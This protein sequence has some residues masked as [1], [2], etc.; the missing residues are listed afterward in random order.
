MNA[1]A[2]TQKLAAGASIAR[3]FEACGADAARCGSASQELCG[4]AARHAPAFG[5][6][7]GLGKGQRA[8]VRFA[9]KRASSSRVMGVLRRDLSCHD[10][11]HLKEW[12]SRKPGAVHPHSVASHRVSNVVH[13]WLHELQL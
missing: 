1:S 10:S 9:A 12:A 2:L 7:L 11:I 8:R 6:A 5:G 3:A 13:A 4:E